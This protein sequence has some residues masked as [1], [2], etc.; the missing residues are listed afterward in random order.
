[1]VDA[2]WPQSQ[3]READWQGDGAAWSESGNTWRENH[4]KKHPSGWMNKT[5]RFMAAFMTKSWDICNQLVEHYSQNQQVWQ[6]VNMVTEQGESAMKEP[7]LWK[8]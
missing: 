6:L 5:V 7:L 2:A 3:W 4:T 8:P 1:M